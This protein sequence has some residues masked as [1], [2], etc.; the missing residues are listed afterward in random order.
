LE[1]IHALCRK[2]MDQSGEG[3][4]P[5][6]VGMAAFEPAPEGWAPGDAGVELGSAATN[7]NG[8]VEAGVTGD[9]EGAT[10]T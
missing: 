3:A 1:A 9:D 4:T 6:V 7:G 8:A 2:R 5:M 10:S